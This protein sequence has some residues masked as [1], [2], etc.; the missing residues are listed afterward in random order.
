MNVVIRINFCEIADKGFN[1][2]LINADIRIS[3][4]EIKIIHLEMDFS[5]SFL[6]TNPIW[7]IHQI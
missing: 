4:S 2:V 7:I 6:Q 3:P 5:Y 1:I